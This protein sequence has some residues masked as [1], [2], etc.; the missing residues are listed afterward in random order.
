MSNHVD[1]GLKE[2]STLSFEQP[3]TRVWILTSYLL[4]VV[5]AVPLWWSTTSIERLS[6]P[7]SRVDSL[8]SKEVSRWIN[9][10]FEPC[11]TASQL[12]LPVSVAVDISNP[13]TPSD[14]LVEK[15]RTI[16]ELRRKDT[17]ALYSHLDFS[18]DFFRGVSQSFPAS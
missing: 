17:P 5:L 8:G 14:G 7:T 9:G 4:L 10:Y 13:G 3:R 6:L 16:F 12:H 1:H 2:P 15:L 18:V 11:L